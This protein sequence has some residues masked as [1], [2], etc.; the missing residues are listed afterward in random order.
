[1]SDESSSA[2]ASC[3]DK[4]VNLQESLYEQKCRFAQEIFAGNEE[5]DKKEAKV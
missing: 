3:G 4:G 1:V 5:V 2:V